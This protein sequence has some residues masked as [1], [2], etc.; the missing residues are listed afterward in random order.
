LNMTPLHWAVESGELDIV[1]LLLKSGAWPS[2]RNKFD[3]TP[4]DIAILNYRDDMI[5]ILKNA[6]QL[7]Q[8]H[9]EELIIE[10]ESL[11]LNSQV[12]NQSLYNNNAINNNNINGNY[13][14]GV[15]LNTIGQI[16]N[17]N[18]RANPVKHH[19]V[20]NPYNIYQNSYPPLN[21]HNNKM[22][23]NNNFLFALNNKYRLKHQQHQQNQ[24]ISIKGQQY[25]TNPQSISKINQPNNLGNTPSQVIK[26]EFLP[27]GQMDLQ[28]SNVVIKSEF[29]SENY[30][31]NSPSNFNNTA[32]MTSINESSSPRKY[33][34][35]LAREL[36]SPNRSQAQNDLNQISINNSAYAKPKP[37]NKRIKLSD[38]DSVSNSNIESKTSNNQQLFLLINNLN[39]SS[40]SI[41]SSNI[42]NQIN[43]L[44]SSKELGAKTIGK[45][46]LNINQINNLLLC[47]SLKVSNVS[48]HNTN[49]NSNI[50]TQANTNPNTRNHIF[51]QST[52]TQDKNLRVSKLNDILSHSHLKGLNVSSIDNIMAFSSSS[53]AP[54]PCFVLTNSGKVLSDKEW[55]MEK[56]NK[57]SNNEQGKQFYKRDYS[58]FALISTSSDNKDSPNSKSLP[59]N[60]S[61]DI[62]T[63]DSLTEKDNLLLV[64]ENNDHNLLL[65]SPTTEK[66]LN[67]EAQRALSSLSMPL[68]INPQIDNNNNLN[69][70]IGFTPITTT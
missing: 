63:F 69:T 28:N 5:T 44:S 45:R 1:E 14:C 17:T 38:V 35:A 21:A 66:T 25:H 47:K 3:K 46:I 16:R 54:L 58:S 70:D 6:E 10:D 65:F 41:S 30:N 9:E 49:I 22:N 53:A 56:S 37:S 7:Q 27:L 12:L 39:N 36:T 4:M 32:Y 40:T 23:L 18:K 33:L 60:E 29:T 26:Q 24:Q 52:D 61:S 67:L 42:L 2:A 55:S 34:Q 48:S 20:N 57:L 68:K 64:D 51:L 31:V 19:L 11:H 43:N 59:T 8:I 13:W 62:I 50:M 15:G